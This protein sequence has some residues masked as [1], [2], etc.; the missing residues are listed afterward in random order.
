MRKSGFGQ[1]TAVLAKVSP[2]ATTDLVHPALGAVF[3]GPLDVRRRVVGN[4]VKNQYYRYELFGPRFRLEIALPEV[5]K[6]RLR[7][8][9]SA[10]VRIRGNRVMLWK[11]IISRFENWLR[12]K[13]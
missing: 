4:G 13:Q 12:S 2:T 5:L 8:G 1:F 9:Q 6:D 10:L 3:G 7:V 11:R